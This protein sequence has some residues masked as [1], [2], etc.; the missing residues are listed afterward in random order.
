MFVGF[1]V[2]TATVVKS[3][4]FWYAKACSR[5]KVDVYIGGT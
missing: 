3:S 1:V 2:L 4:V 5:L